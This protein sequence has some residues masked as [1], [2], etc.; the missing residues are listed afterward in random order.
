M[1]HRRGFGV[2]YL[3][4]FPDAWMMSGQ[5]GKLLAGAAG[6]YSPWG[7]ESEEQGH[8]ILL[9]A[10]FMKKGNA[11][12]RPPVRAFRLT[13]IRVREKRMNTYKTAQTGRSYQNINKSICK[14]SFT[15]GN[16]FCCGTYY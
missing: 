16:L 4:I 11:S 12:H 14:K 3:A 1:L 13:P 6:F 10:F 9:S 15:T 5:E 7:S 2:C 8:R